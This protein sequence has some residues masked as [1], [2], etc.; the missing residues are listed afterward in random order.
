MAFDIKDI[1]Y[2]NKKKT[3]RGVSRTVA[4]DPYQLRFFVPEGFVVK[5]VKLTNKLQAAFKTEGNLLTVDYN[6]P[7][8]TDV[9]WTI[10]F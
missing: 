3:L 7:T 2:D 6:S 5:K 1:T 10:Y 4:G 9:E 8:G